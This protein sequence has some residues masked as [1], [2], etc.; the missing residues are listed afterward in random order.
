MCV[1]VTD[2][3]TD[4]EREKGQDLTE[5]KSYIPPNASNTTEKQRQLH[6]L[7]SKHIKPATKQFPLYSPPPPPPPR[8]H[9]CPTPNTPSLPPTLTPLWATPEEIVLPL[10][11]DRG[12][13][14]VDGE[15]LVVGGHHAAQHKVLVL[16]RLHQVHHDLRHV[17]RA[18]L[19][20]GDG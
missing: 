1:C 5:D 7:H 10:Q 4:K 6:Q 13:L 16:A 12:V 17:G 11:A 14:G 9:P 3:E 18:P 8:P 19:D 2:R 15:A 20:P